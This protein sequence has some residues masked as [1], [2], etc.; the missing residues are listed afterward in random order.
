M[1]TD[2]DFN[3]IEIL[4]RLDKLEAG[5]PAIHFGHSLALQFM[6]L[7]ILEEVASDEQ[8]ER[9]HKR[10][11]AASLDQIISTQ[12]HVGRDETVHETTQAAL[13]SMLTRIRGHID[14]LLSA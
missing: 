6:L 7:L 8:L 2:C 11:V 1:T 4:G 5:V 9:I 3:P 10:L 14:R 12:P 13:H